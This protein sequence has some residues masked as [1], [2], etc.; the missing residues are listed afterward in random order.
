[1]KWISV[2]ERLPGNGSVVLAVTEYRHSVSTPTLL[3]IDGDWFT[4]DG[5]K[6]LSEVTH[7]QPLPAPPSG[8]E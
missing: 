2:K 1:M 3:W 6:L 4:Y 8:K 7:W 5:Y